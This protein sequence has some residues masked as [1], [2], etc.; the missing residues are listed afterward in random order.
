LLAQLGDF[1]GLVG[2][3]LSGDEFKFL[4]TGE[5]VFELIGLIVA[6]VGKGFAVGLGRD[7]YLAGFGEFSLEATLRASGG[8]DFFVE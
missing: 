5:G 4:D 6:R 8:G 7:F 2:G 3:L 1:D